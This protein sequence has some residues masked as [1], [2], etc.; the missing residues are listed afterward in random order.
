MERP[1]LFTRPFVLAALANLCMCIAGF[2]FVHLPGLLQEL[3]A[4]EAQIGRIMA[5]SALVA[6][7]VGPLLGRVMDER[8]RRVVIVA[9]AALF[10]VAIALY[11]AVDRISPFLYAVRALEGCAGTMLYASLFTYAADHVPA[12]RRTEG[13][14][15]FGAS[16]LLPIA[17]GSALGDAILAHGDYRALFAVSFAFGVAGLVLALP[18]RDAP[19]LVARSELRRGVVAAVRQR[20]LVPVWVAAFAFFFA[21]GGLFTFFKTFVLLRG[22]GGVGGFFTAYALVA[23]SVRFFSGRLLDRMG[24][25]RMLAPALGFYAAGLVLLA[26]ADTSGQVLAAGA[27]CGLGHG[28]TYPILFSLVV[29]RAGSLERGSAVAFYTA[30]DASGHFMAGP[31]LG[32][33]IEGAGYEVGYVAAACTVCAGIALFYVLDRRARVV[34]VPVT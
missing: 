27:L 33:L 21:A 31:L 22:I 16:G 11:F 2:L 23:M 18:L 25:A 28:Y 10:L 13:L 9:G 24:P 15:I 4:G 29:S 1:A 8:G 7:A 17:L 3:G 14:A 26:V 6:V 30:V 5:T 32:W 20:D 19:G 12:E 34:R